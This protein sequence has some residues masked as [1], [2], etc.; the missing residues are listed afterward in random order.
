MHT[1]LVLVWLVGSS[2]LLA[3]PAAAK[4]QS[5]CVI[6]RRGTLDAPD[7]SC[8]DKYAADTKDEWATRICGRRTFWSV[9][10]SSFPDRPS[11]SPLAPA[12]PP[13]S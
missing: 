1:F 11:L 12:P 13:P 9:S 5:Q 3:V 8:V 2:L 10:H 6:A 7:P 4:T